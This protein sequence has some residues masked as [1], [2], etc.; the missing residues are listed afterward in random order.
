MERPREKRKPLQ[1]EAGLGGMQPQAQECW[2][3]WKLREAGEGS[4]LDRAEEHGPAHT[5]I[6]DAWPPEL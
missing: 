3:N 2:G 5:L 1:M 4:L 6:F